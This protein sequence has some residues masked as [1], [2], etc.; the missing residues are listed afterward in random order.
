MAL[1][2]GN[3]PTTVIPEPA[4]DDILV[5]ETTIEI[6]PLAKEE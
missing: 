1:A 6:L 5:S 2:Q 4:P 3:S